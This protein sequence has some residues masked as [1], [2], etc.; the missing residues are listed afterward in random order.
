MIHD[1][2]VPLVELRDTSKTFT[3]EAEVVWAVRDVSMRAH[4]GEFVC[5]HGPSGAGKSTLLNLIVGLDLADSGEIQVNACNVSQLDE[6]SRATL[7][8][9]SVGVVFQDDALIEEFTAEENV[10]LPLEARGDDTRTALVKAADL[11]ATVGLEG[12][13]GRW[14]R[15]LS[16]GQR[17]RVG[18]ARALAGGRNIIVADEPTGSLDSKTSAE[19]FELIAELCRS[20][21]LA[22]VCSHDP[23]CRTY[24]STVYEM[25]D[26]ELRPSAS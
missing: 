9:Q 8:R 17:Q 11:L 19:L 4:A 1:P 26:G 12:M 25:V 15:Q 6:N 14:P 2:A 24:A 7:R 16:G 10:A 13:G 22:I 5:I 21:T 23:L 3:N 18:V 20:G